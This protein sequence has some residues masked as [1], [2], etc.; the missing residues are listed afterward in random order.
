MANDYV[1]IYRNLVRRAARPRLDDVLSANGG[2]RVSGTEPIA[3]MS[4]HAD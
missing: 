4:T 1:R 2:A 3:D